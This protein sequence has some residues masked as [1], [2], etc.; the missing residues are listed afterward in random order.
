MFKKILLFVFVSIFVLN[1]AFSSEHFSKLDATSKYLL[2]KL[3]RSLKDNSDKL[4]KRLNKHPFST[5]NGKTYVS[6]LFEANQ[7]IDSSDLLAL[8]CIYLVKTGNI[9]SLELPL[10]NLDELLSKYWVT[11]VQ[12][13]REFKRNLDKSKVHLRV[14][15]VHSGTNIPYPLQGENVIIGIFDTGIDFNHPDFSDTNG[16]RILYLWDM[17]DQSSQNPPRGFDWGKEY[18]KIDIDGSPHLVIQ[19]DFNGH[20]THVAG[21]AAGNG[22]GKAQFKGIAPKSKLIVVKGVR[23]PY[24]STFD[25][26]DIIAGCNY[27]FSKADELS[28]PCVINLSLSSLLGSHDGEDLLSKSLDNLVAQK[29]GR[30]I[31]ASAGNAGNYQI[32]SGG[33]ISAGDNRDLLVDPVINI[34]ELFPTVCPDDPYYFMTGAEVWVDLQVLDSIFVFA[35]DQFNFDLI[36]G[37]GFSAH[38]NYSNVPLFTFEGY[39]YGFFD[40]ATATQGDSQNLF[41]FIGN[42]GDT[43]IPVNQHLWLI[44]FSAKNSGK[45][46]TWSLVPIGSQYQ[47]NTPNQRFPSDNFMTIGSPAVAKNVI[48][49]GSYVTK[50]SFTNVFGELVDYSDSLTIGQIS[51]FSSRG[52]SRDGRILPTILAPGEYIF[53][54]LSSD[55]NLNDELSNSVDPSG[56]YVGMN[57]TSM[58]APQVAGAIALLLQVDPNLN[59]SEVIELVKRACRV[60]SFTGNIP[61]NNAGWGKLDV[62]K[63]VQFVS[64]VEN[65]SSNS[66][67]PLLSPNPTSGLVMLTSEGK[68]ENV[69][70][71]DLF[72]RRLD[73]S[74]ENDFLDLSSAPIGVYLVRVTIGGKTLLKHLV[75]Y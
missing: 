63:L 23:D 74:N 35:I 11:R 71:Y 10:D 51:L 31:V 25:D 38:E 44:T 26:G 2:H 6:L 16:T 52:P 30:I 24:G 73:F 75:K 15:E 42:E 4:L 41:V 33:I 45:I 69:E 13:S 65:S 56:I 39:L 59:Y 55:A 53:S 3:N 49:V 28:L 60:D 50:N 20:G 21:C 62:L 5:R 37:W 47:I 48:S 43:S 72:G 67:V 8:N 54:A 36:G 27:I 68:I 40:Q 70:I 22:N 66:N 19:K 64:S 29:N 61:N 12:F 17:S 57:G 1:I 18:T 14:N 9:Y 7:E 34:C 46:D 58:S 32:H